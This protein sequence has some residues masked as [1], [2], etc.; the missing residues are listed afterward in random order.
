MF[1]RAEEYVAEVLA[2]DK[3]NVP[4]LAQLGARPP[5]AECNAQCRKWRTACNLARCSEA[6][7]PY[8]NGRC[9]RG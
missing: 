6:Y 9:K 7:L 4:A 3:K 1:G 8:L 2:K 5:A